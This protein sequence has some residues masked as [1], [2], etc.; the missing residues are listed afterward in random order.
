MNIFITFGIPWCPDDDQQRSKHVDRQYII[1]TNC[2][3]VGV[4]I[5]ILRNTLSNRL[6]TTFT[7]TSHLSLF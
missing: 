3:F 1:K 7:I 4:M 2:A 6:I 5:S